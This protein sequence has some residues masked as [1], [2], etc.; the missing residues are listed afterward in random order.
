VL[1]AF[2]TQSEKII[3]TQLL[4]MDEEESFVGPDYV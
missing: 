3:Q 1:D 2:F 4:L